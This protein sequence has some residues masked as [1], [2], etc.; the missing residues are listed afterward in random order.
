[1]VFCFEDACSEE[2][3]PA[4]E[5]NVL[6]VLDALSTALDTGE[7]TYDYLPLIFCR[8][9]NQQQFEH[10]A[11]QLTPHHVKVL[12]DS[13]FQSSMRTM[14]RY[15]CIIFKNSMINSARLFT[16]CLLLKILK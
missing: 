14:R 2:L 16:E 12:L 15:I 4:A 5:Q 8:V 3:V 6:H 13:I 9:R 1:M 11:E 7:L 10:F